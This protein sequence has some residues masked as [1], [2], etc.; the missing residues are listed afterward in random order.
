MAKL[1]EIIELGEEVGEEV[2][3]EAGE[4]AAEE[5]AE[6]EV[7]EEMAEVREN[8]GRL[9]RCINALKEINWGQV[10]IQ[11]AKFVA[12]NA[13][14]GGIFWG[15]TVGLNKLIAKSSGSEKLALQTKQKKIKAMAHLLSDIS[16]CFKKLADWI[17]EKKDITVDVGGGIVVP[18]PD[19]L[20]K[21]TKPL[22]KVSVV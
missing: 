20:I 15:V 22:E 19:V 5:A 3:E 4:E 9:R 16:D 11:V 10:V 2:G 17:E 21:Y 7:A 6:E 13:V 1:E 12:K 14:I 8:V 18:L